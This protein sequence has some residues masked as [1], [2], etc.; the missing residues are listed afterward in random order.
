MFVT[1]RTRSPAAALAKCCKHKTG[2]D[3]SSEI[4]HL[5]ISV[6]GQWDSFWL[7]LFFLFS[8][9]H[10]EKVNIIYRRGYVHLRLGVCACL[11]DINL[12]A[13]SQKPVLKA[14]AIKFDTVIASVT[15]M[16]RMLIILTLTFIQGHTDLN[17][18]NNKCLI[19]SETVQAMPIKYQVY[20][21]HYSK[22]Y[23]TFELMTF[24]F[25]LYYYHYNMQRL[26]ICK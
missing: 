7:K 17:H 6:F 1:A 4:S 5:A 3:T 26:L 12:P 16:H 25:V 9:F 13:I 23:S 8:K 21:E 10:F 11:S 15:R 20:C 22:L 19:I 2:K 14:I 24:V 18:E